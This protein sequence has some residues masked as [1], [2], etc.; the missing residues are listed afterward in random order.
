MRNAKLVLWN[1]LVW[2]EVIFCF[3]ADI[4]HYLFW[5]ALR[6]LWLVERLVKK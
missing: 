4:P 2:V 3:E 6:A 1:S 5:L